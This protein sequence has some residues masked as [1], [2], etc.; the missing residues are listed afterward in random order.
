MTP[1]LIA[2]PERIRRAIDRRPG[3][4]VSIAAAAA[5]SPHAAP[6]VRV[7]V[8]GARPPFRLYLYVDGDLAE[9]WIPA[10]E[11]NELACPT[12]AT[13]RHTVTA[14]AVDALGRWGGASILA[15]GV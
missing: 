8:D 2:A 15:P 5:S 6:V 3:L 13:G 4:E 14:R 1:V 11:T 12:L 10:A 7:R 9:A